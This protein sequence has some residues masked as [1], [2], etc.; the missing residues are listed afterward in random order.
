[1][2]RL[3]AVLQVLHDIDEENNGGR[4]VEARG[5]RGQLNLDFIGLLAIF[6]RILG[7]KVFE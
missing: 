3:P 2:D 4:S 6:R 1:M 5:L 7:D